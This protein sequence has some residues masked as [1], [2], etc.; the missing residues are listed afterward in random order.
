M[1]TENKLL[2][3]S[4]LADEDL[5]ND[6]YKI[7]VLTSEGK[8]RRPNSATEKPFGVLQNAPAAGEAADIA[9][10]GSGGI[11]KIETSGALVN[12]TIVTI[13]Y[14]D[15]TD[16]G[17]AQAAIA[18]QYPAGMIIEP[19]GA[20]DDLAS[21]LLTPM[22]QLTTSTLNS[23]NNAIA[24]P[25]DSGAI[26]VTASGVCA[27]TS[28]GAETRTLAIPTFIGQEIALID[29]THVGNIV[30]TVSAAVNQAGNNT[31]TF[32][33][34]KDMIVLT[35]MTV[36]AALVWRVTANDGVALTTV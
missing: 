32:G 5:S 15:A 31:L 18:T 10:V 34:V 26:A 19:S 3:V 12:G 4:R 23:M 29:D 6:Q 9:V 33:A 1:A 22:T 24:D 21:V 16:A 17:K 14:V 36:G 11:S 7:V 13:E 35:A 30:I 2:V 28:A 8:V 25:G 27:L 20:E